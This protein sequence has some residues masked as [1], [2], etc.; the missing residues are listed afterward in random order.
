MADTSP[1]LN[2]PYILPAQAQKHVTHNEA[3]RLLDMI[4]QLA[5][6]SRTLSVPPGAPVVGERYIVAAGATGAW[7]GKVGKIAVW[8]ETGWV[9]VTPMAG[10][11][12]YVAAEAAD[13][14]FDGTAWVTAGLPSQLPQLGINATASAT[15]RL[16]VSAE[17]TLLN[18]AGAGHQ[19]KVNKAAVAD[20]ASL[21]FQTGF[22]GRAEMGLAG[23]D[24]FSVKVSA[25]GVSFATALAASAATGS[26]TL[27][28]PVHLG[29]QAAD[30]AGPVNGTLWLNTTTG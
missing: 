28:Q 25:D 2:L 3:I 23:S 26:V 29:G 21:L 20:T 4:V 17:A 10:W 19:V 30:P 8:G 14:T 16:T 27:P 15:N 7:A 5:V 9:Y 1:I 12:A 6:T 13:A 11:Q 18:N 24:D 22:S